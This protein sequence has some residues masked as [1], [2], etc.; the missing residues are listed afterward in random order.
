MFVLT[1]SKSFG[2][3]FETSICSRGQL[4]QN[5]PDLDGPG[6]SPCLLG[7]RQTFPF[8]RRF[9]FYPDVT[10]QHFAN[11]KLSTQYNS[12]TS[13]LRYKNK[14]EPQG[15]NL[16]FFK[17]Q[18]FFNKIDDQINDNI[19]FDNILASF[20]SELLNSPKKNEKKIISTTY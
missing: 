10:V 11:S 12:E 1:F 13:F 7:W 16:C 3:F 14:Q 20:Y 18:N 8:G 4:W 17:H 5:D 19:I 2:P 9:V 15:T 6:T